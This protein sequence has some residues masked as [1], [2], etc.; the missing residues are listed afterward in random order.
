MAYSPCELAEM[1]ELHRPAFI[2]RGV[3]DPARGP[4]HGG[5]NGSP[6][7]A[8][9]PLTSSDDPDEGRFTMP[10]NTDRHQA[11]AVRRFEAWNATEPEA[12]GKS[13]AET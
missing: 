5:A 13:P 1:R 12:P 8:I 2:T 6:R 11:A 4:G 9:N 3:S 10:V 7:T